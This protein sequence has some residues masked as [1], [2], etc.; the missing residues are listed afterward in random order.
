M[1]APLFVKAF[2]H[3]DSQRVQLPV[4]QATEEANDWMEVNYEKIELVSH[5]VSVTHAPHGSTTS[6]L[7]SVVVKYHNIAQLANAPATGQTQKLDPAVAAAALAAASNEPPFSPQTVRDLE[8]TI[9]TAFIHSS[10]EQA[11]Q[12]MNH[13]VT[14]LA[15]ALEQGTCI[16][17]GETLTLMYD[18]IRATEQ[19]VRMAIENGTYH[20]KS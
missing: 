9:N 18:L 14:E 10:A 16:E 4:A 19:Q 15:I 7:C 2:A 12:W 13:G 5:E 3:E 1:K 11:Q 17:P 20:G 6:V 8:R